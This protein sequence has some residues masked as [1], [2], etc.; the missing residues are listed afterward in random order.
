[1][2]TTVEVGIDAIGHIHPLDPKA[3]LPEG[4]ALLTWAITVA[5]ETMH[6]SEKSLADEWLNPEEDSAW[7]HLQQAK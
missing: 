6:Q 4:R 3:P 2:S 5:E 1:M 7:A